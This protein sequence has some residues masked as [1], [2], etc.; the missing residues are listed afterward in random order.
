MV[1]VID[2]ETGQRVAAAELDPYSFDL[3]TPDEILRG[4]LE[5]IS[6]VRQTNRTQSD[7]DP[8]EGETDERAELATGPEA[9][10]EPS[11]EYLKSQMRRLLGPRYAVVDDPDDN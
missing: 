10:E 11:P 3:H 5:D 2:T 9:L 1:V 8:L 7:F 6:E 4:L